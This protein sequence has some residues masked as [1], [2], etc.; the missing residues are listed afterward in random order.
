M[1]DRPSSSGS[2]S[3]VPRLADVAGRALDTRS[4]TVFTVRTA[5]MLLGLAC[6]Q[7]A[8]AADVVYH[9]GTIITLDS[10]D[11]VASAVA[12]RGERILAVG[13]RAEV[14]AAA[15]PDARVLDLQGATMLP[16]F[17]DAHGHFP[18][19]GLLERHFVDLNSPP[20]GPV[21]DLAD[22]LARLKKRAAGTPPGEWIRGRGY[23][24]TLLAEGRHPTRQ[25]LD[26]VSTE[27]PILIGHISGHLSVANTLAL[28]LAGI[29]RQ[30]S[31]PAGGRFRRDAAGEPNGVM[32]E[33]AAMS[34]VSRLVPAFS[35]ADMV[36]AIETAGRR[37]AAVGVTTAQTGA[38]GPQAVTQ[39][40][41]A[42][43]AGRL[44]IRVQIWPVIQV[45]MLML[46]DKVDV[47]VPSDQNW[48]TI[49]AVKGFADGSIQGY[50]GYLGE[51]YHVQ[52]EDR[53]PGYRGYPTVDREELTAMVKRVHAAGYQLAIHGNGDAAIDNVLFAL[54]AAQ[55]A[56]PRADARHIVI[57]AQMAREDQLDTMAK[58]GVIPSFFNLHTFY[59]GDRH[60]DIFM[61]P[62][63]AARM[64]P[65]RS[66]VE[67]SMPFTL[68]ADTPVVPMTPMK[69]VWAAVNRLTSSGRVIGA[70]QR[71]SVLDALKGITRHAAW[72][73]FEEQH[74]GTIEVGKL[75]DLVVLDRNPLRTRP[76][77]LDTIQ[78]LRTIV[79][80]A[81]AYS[82]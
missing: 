13:T 4:A 70:E 23:D 75:A 27:H 72:Q 78:V 74:K 54:A 21:R 16:G 8:P 45:A 26:R 65:A 69:I 6:S 33:G 34:Q 56:Q 55:E 12:V 36:D 61:G 58:M 35:E 50:T 3:G 2:F 67:R 39:T 9:G 32:E 64:S 57:H 11:A 68:H 20:I 59:W 30:T 71:I 15:N 18:S 51:P 60:R 82:R 10:A 19:S 53:G 25:D 37:Y 29:S 44:P 5:F 42:F 46:D 38:A 14:A 62:A 80:G 22:L 41:A 1:R 76:S 66:A 79:G 7:A 28:K 73:G 24:D 63:R 47:A 49:G 17:I 81:T 52:P 48:V 31:D 40:L 77:E 43:K